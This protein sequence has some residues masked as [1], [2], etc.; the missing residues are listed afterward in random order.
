[1]VPTNWPGLYVDP[2]EFAAQMEGLKAAGWHPVTL[3]RLRAYWT[4]GV[5]LGPGKPVVGTE[6][7]EV[8]IGDLVYIARDE[9]DFIA[10]LGEITS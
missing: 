1:M 9:C 4:H 6:M 3:D 2:D 7:P 8:M 10:R 5:P